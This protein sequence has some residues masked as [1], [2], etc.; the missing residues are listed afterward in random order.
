VTKSL[1][2]RPHK[3]NKQKQKTKNKTKNPKKKQQTNKQTNK[4]KTN[5]HESFISC[6]PRKAAQ[7][8]N[9][10][11]KRDRAIPMDKARDSE[12]TKTNKNN[13]PLKKKRYFSKY[14]LL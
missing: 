2:S 11:F 5:R 1:Y 8:L 6:P 12:D 14:P 7:N 10:P 13:L 3:K 4:Q 9:K